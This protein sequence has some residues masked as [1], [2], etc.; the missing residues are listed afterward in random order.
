MYNE[1]PPPPPEPTL[2][3]LEV[4]SRPTQNLTYQSEIFVWCHVECSCLLTWMARSAGSRM[5]GKMASLEQPALPK[6]CALGCERPHCRCFAGIKFVCLCSHPSG[7]MHF[8]VK[9][10]SSPVGADLFY[11]TGPTGEGG[12]DDATGASG[13]SGG[14]SMKQTIGRPKHHAGKLC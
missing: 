10:A 3:F 13:A 12:L 6:V 1:S 14:A 11:Q 5:S 7:P 2:I 9:H 4:G 8:A